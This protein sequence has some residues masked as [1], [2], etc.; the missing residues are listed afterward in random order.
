MLK[1]TQTRTRERRKALERLQSSTTQ[2]QQDALL[3]F[4]NRVKITDETP[5][6]TE[7]TQGLDL[8]VSPTDR[9]SLPSRFLYARKPAKVRA[10]VT[11]RGRKDTTSACL[12]DSDST[13][14]L[15][16]I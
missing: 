10:V 6:I 12:S 2:Y 14:Q 16:Q 8:I 11:A 1:L 3:T 7:L 5:L 13:Q 15:R 9:D 4:E